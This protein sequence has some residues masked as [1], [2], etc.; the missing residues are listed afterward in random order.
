[1]MFGLIMLSLWH[2]AHRSRTTVHDLGI[3]NDHVT[4]IICYCVA[5]LGTVLA[6]VSMFL[7]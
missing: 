7:L 3:R 5:G 1:I 2:A 6:G 4:A